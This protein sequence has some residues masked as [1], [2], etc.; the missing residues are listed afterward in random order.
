MDRQS[1]S[2]ADRIDENIS[3][4]PAWARPPFWGM[5]FVY[6]FMF[7]K[8][9]SFGGAVVLVLLIVGLVQEGFDGLLQAL[10]ML[11]GVGLAG[12]AGGIAYAIVRPLTRRLGHIGAFPAWWVGVAMYLAA[13]FRLLGSGPSPM[14]DDP[15]DLGSRAGQVTLTI[16]SAFF[17]SICAAV[18]V[19]V[20]RD[21]ARRTRRRSRR[22]VQ[23]KQRVTS[24]VH[25]PSG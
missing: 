18:E 1:E 5:M 24:R 22:W 12:F 25:P 15:I 13:V 23:R 6:V 7:V 17:G 10:W 11:V 8:L 3:A 4:L 9:A 2:W 19:D 20:L 14:L 21:W 16:L